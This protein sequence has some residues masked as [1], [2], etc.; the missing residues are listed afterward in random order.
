[1]SFCHSQTHV[2]LWPGSCLS[3]EIPN[4]VRFRPKQVEN[5]RPVRVTTTTK[6]LQ[7]FDYRL[8]TI[9]FRLQTSDYRLQTSDYRLQTSDYRLQTTDFRLQ[10]TDFRL[11]TTDFNLH[12]S[13]NGLRLPL[14]IFFHTN[15]HKCPRPELARLSTYKKERWAKNCS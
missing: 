8:Q 14:I 11:Q 4:I 10:T 3:L 6:G 9:D 13:W 7:S 1:M 15:V 5:F 2:Y 12:Y